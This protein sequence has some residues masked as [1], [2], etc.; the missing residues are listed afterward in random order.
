M[1]TSLRNWMAL[2]SV[3]KKSQRTLKGLDDFH[4]Y[5]VVSARVLREDES[6]SLD[7]LT[8]NAFSSP[9]TVLLHSGQSL[10]ES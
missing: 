6:Q 10:S 3:P 5:K 4:I 9:P 1:G 2:A 7:F 8:Y